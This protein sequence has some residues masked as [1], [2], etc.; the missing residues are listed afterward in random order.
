M[1]TILSLGML[2][3]AYADVASW[4]GGNFHGKK[5]AD[6]STYNQNAMTA[7]AAPHIKMGS[8]LKVTNISNN[9]SVIVKV[10][11]RGAFHK[12]KYGYRTLDLSK[13]AAR[14]I[15]VIGPGTAKVRVELI[16]MASNKKQTSIAVMNG[17]KPYIQV[18]VTEDKD[19][20]INIKN[21][22]FSNTSKQ[23]FLEP[24]NG[25]YRI[26]IGPLTPKEA[27]SVLKNVQNIGYTNAFFTA[28]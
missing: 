25:V 3:S 24:Q 9:K 11:D 22:V 16:K 18:F 23:A 28:D 8:K 5:A 1:T 26:K 7:A 4:Y 17:F 21:Q 2:S 13:G 20:A 27:N 14:A 6:G 19:K 12:A 15:G 10:T